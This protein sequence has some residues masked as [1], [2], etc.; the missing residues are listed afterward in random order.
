MI[1]AE[2]GV[3]SDFDPTRPRADQWDVS[4]DLY[5]SVVSGGNDARR[6]TWDVGLS[7][8]SGYHV[9]IDYAR[10]H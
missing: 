6:Y 1:M 5:G 4:S 7:G 2:N 9:P 3:H 10:V 8:L